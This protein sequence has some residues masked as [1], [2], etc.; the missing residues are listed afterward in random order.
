MKMM[1]CLLLAALVAACSKEGKSDKAAEG[2]GG[3]AGSAAPSEPAKPSEPAE[4]NPSSGTAKPSEPS[5]PAKPTEPSEP[6]GE[7]VAPTAADVAKYTEG[8]QGTG[9]LMARFKTS[10]GEINCEL[11]E[12]DAPMTVANFVGLARGLH[13]F[14]DPRDGKVKKQPFFDGL[15]FHRVIPEFMIQGGDPLGQGTGGPGY[16]FAQEVSPKLLHVPGTLSMANA[17]PGTNGSQFFITEAATKQLDG[18][19]NVFGKCAEID[20]VKSIAR[21][22]RGPRDKPN[23]DVVMEKVEIYRK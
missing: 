1:R 10:M 11:F 12:K 16:E 14:Q 7:V 2:E 22:D 8:L 20:V 13:A 5:E 6:A 21:V 23:T 18:G 9:T 4:P 3:G 19:Y 17:G 15:I